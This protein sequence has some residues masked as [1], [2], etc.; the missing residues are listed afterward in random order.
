[1]SESDLL[2]PML[3]KGGVSC[4]VWIERDAAGNEI[5]VKQPLEKLKVV[6][7]WHSN[8]ERYEVEARALTA[9]RDLLGDR[10]APK[11]LWV[12]SSQHR[13]AMERIDPRF[14]NWKS[15][16]LAGHID[17]STAASVGKSLGQLHARSSA[18]SE[19]A[20]EFGNTVYFEELRIEPFFS[21]IAARNPAFESGID[22]AI[23]ILREQRTTLVH[24]DFSPKNLLVDREEV[25]IL[26]CEIMHWGNPRFDIAF[27]LSHLLLKGLRAGA[28]RARF[29]AAIRAYLD[30]YRTNGVADAFD[31]ALTR[32]LGCL[33]LS[34]FE[35]ASPVD[36]RDDIDATYVKR[37]ASECIV[38]P[39]S[40][41]FDVVY[42][43]LGLKRAN[44]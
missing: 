28:D 19:L 10:A 29:A 39:K 27:C 5:V 40:D 14:R 21:R 38:H 44:E 32:I 15:E 18:R 24:G 42:P 17:L 16:L 4:E 31:A 3:L 30:S 23:G 7:D 26:D 34:R 9:I 33:L 8:P 25:V 13:F 2:K 6:A 37:I 22:Q 12:D 11:V 35:G 1:M 20:V 41:V 43:A 36:Y